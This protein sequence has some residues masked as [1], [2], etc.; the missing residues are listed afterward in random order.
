MTDQRPPEQDRDAGLSP[1]DSLPAVTGTGAKRTSNLIILVCFFFLLGGSG[2]VLY[3]LPGAQNDRNQSSASVDPEPDADLET[4]AA[5]PPAFP[6]AERGE[7]EKILESLLHLKIQAEAEGVSRWGEEHYQR[8]LAIGRQGDAFLA[9]SKFSD[10]ANSYRRA[11]SE[12]G[13]LL[14]SK[15]DL[16]QA[17]LTGAQQA[18]A[19]KQ[20]Q[21]AIL[22]YGRAL[23]INPTDGQALAGREKALARE[24]VLELCHQA[25]KFEASGNQRAAVVKLEDL[26]KLDR[27]YEPGLSAL[28]R[29]KQIV[30]NQEFSQEL[31]SFYNHLESGALTEA[32]TA[33]ESLKRLKPQHP[34]VN[35]AGLVLAENEEAAIVTAMRNQAESY[36]KAER[37]QDALV[38]YRKI[39]ALAPEALFAVNGNKEA[40]K[41]LELDK[42]MTD[43][44]GQPERLQDKLQRETAAD[45]LRYAGFIVPGG[46]RLQ[47]QIRELQLL[48]Y[49]ANSE[50]TITIESDN[51]TD[52]TMYHVGRLGRFFSREIILTPGSYTVVG[53][54]VGYHDIRKTIKISSKITAKPFIIKC[55]EP[56]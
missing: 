19:Q 9:D 44:L 34:Q 5:V 4:A 22:L 36:V 21:E 13:G 38:V 10:A 39:I 2:A 26:L 42:S 31:S 7:A 35:Q 47:S 30:E 55:N 11:V 52:I 8:I 45:L 23:A 53:S 49:E 37:W 15:Q 33:F 29:L 3:L 28:R 48:L 50:L 1:P 51:M 56:I 40:G 43:I 32:R 14:S 6:E 27:T 41:R 20:T 17:L 18:L 24:K 25:E 12:L 46:P 16:F 54:R